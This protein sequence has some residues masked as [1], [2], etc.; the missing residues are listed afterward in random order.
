MP[1]LVTVDSSWCPQ[2]T[3]GAFIRVCA[4]IRHLTVSRNGQMTPNSVNYPSMVPFSFI[5]VAFKKGMPTLVEI[6][7]LVL[8]LPLL[9]GSHA[10]FDRSPLL[11]ERVMACTTPA[12]EMAYTNAASRL[13]TLQ[14]NIDT[15]LEKKVQHL[16]DCC[17]FYPL[18]CN[19]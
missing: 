15:E 13:P 7:Y 2:T 11:H 16:L 5:Y 1:V 14:S 4:F 6:H 17:L 19:S 3:G 18:C 8:T 10:Q 9:V 12:D